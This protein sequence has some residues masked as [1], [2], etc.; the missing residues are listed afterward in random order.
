M[1]SRGFS[2]RIIII[3]NLVSYQENFERKKSYFVKDE[4]VY[5]KIQPQTFFFNFPTY[6][7][8]VRVH[9]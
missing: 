3:I 9:V 8:Q 4:I 7:R 2:Q 6:Q 1:I 5:D